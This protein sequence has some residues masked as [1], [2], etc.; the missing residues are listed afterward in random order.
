[1]SDAPDDRRIRSTVELREALGSDVVVHFTVAAPPALT[2]D[3]RELAI[4]VGQEAL[5]KMEEKVKGGESN[6]VARLNLGAPTRDVVATPDGSRALV[7]TGR[8]VTV[9]D[10]GKLEGGARA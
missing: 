5:Q 6:V 3:V 8:S 4:D 2:D 1:M 7:A 10:L 9:V